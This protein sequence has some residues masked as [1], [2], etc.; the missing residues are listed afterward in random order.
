MLTS[1]FFDL[2]K[3][4]DCAWI[5]GMLHD[6]GNLPLFITGFLWNSRFQMHVN[7]ILSREGCASDHDFACHIINFLHQSHLP[8]TFRATCYIHDLQP[9]ICEY[10]FSSVTASVHHLQTLPTQKAG[11]SHFCHK[12]GFHPDPFKLDT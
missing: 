6:L 7:S 11:C 5:C 9:F 3:V 4:Y 12:H 1:I 10:P 2:E 8:P